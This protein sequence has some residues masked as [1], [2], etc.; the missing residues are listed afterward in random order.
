MLSYDD[1]EDAEE[2]VAALL[3]AGLLG[4]PRDDPSCHTWDW[5]ALLRMLPVPQVRSV[6]REGLGHPMQLHAPPCSRVFGPVG[7]DGSSSASTRC[8]VLPDSR[9]GRLLF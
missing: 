2:A 1:C 4:L 6:P 3:A 9:L 5:A 7:G 8:S